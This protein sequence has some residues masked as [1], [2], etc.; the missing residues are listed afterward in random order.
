MTA[1]QGRLSFS[2]ELPELQLAWDSTSLGALKTC[3]RYYEYAIV[4]G[5]VP[6]D[7]SVHLKFGLAYHESL[8]AYDRA[9]ARGA[10]HHT[11]MQIAVQKALKATWNDQLHRPW[12]SDH[13]TKNRLTLVRTVVWYLLQFESD[14]LETVRLA[15]GKPAVELSFRLDLARPARTG[16]PMLLCGH[17]DRLVENRSRTWVVDYKTTGT[18]ITP[19]WFDRYSPDNQF[20]LY[21]YAG[22]VIYA[23]P[24][25]GL[26]P[27]VAQVGAT[28][29]R[30]QRGFAPRTDDQLE[31]WR[32]D[33]EW[34]LGTAESFAQAGYWPQNDKSC[35]NY[36]GCPYR[37]IC[38]KAP[39][40]RGE[41]LEAQFT[42]R[43]W[44]PLKVRGDI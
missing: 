17:L 2:T 32:E 43:I 44:D 4:A 7:E 19:D 37:R 35:G 29:S 41:W 12:S 22:R 10:D 23:Q 30:F 33:L 40:T 5:Y 42:K 21:T 16:E 3:P 8:E 20:S 9:R 14:P 6:R 31:E 18:T 13:P 15:N 27:A 11:G 34:W 36:G 1:A 24:I 38:G 39:S 28:F 26:I 25:A